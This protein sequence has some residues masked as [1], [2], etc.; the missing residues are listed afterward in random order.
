ML[1]LGTDKLLARVTRGVGY[2][3]FNNPDRHNAVSI[4][5][6]RAL[7]DAMERL[8]ADESVRVVVVAGAGG[9]AFASGADISEFERERD[10]AEQRARYGEI[11]QRG[12]RGLS[13]CSKPV[14]AL[15]QGY[16]L[17]GGLLLALA[18]DLRFAG[19]GASF[20]IPAARL[21]IGFDYTGVAAVARA[22]GPAR[23]ADLL[24][25]ARR[26]DAAEALAAGL[27]QFVAADDRL[28][29]DVEAY[30]RQIADNAPLTLATIKASLR[31]FARYAQAPDTSSID[32][33]VRRCNDSEDHR[34]GRRAFAEKRKPVFQGK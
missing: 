2:V 33:L 32:A 30:A 14:I 1:E 28:V 31:Q 5:M 18:A 27:V 21:G 24:F 3:T 10:D 15:I 13:A 12:F 22:V 26:L 25:S 16:C 11:A 8:E 4:E 7:G 23:T 34:E 19:A 20:G 9:R 6:W 17:G 29:G